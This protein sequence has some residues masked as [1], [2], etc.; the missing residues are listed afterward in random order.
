MIYQIF[1]V[2][3][4]EEFVFRDFLMHGGGGFRGLGIVWSSVVF[5]SFHWWVYDFKIVALLA[6]MA[7]GFIFGLIKKRFDK[8]N[9]NLENSGV[10]AG[11]NTYITGGLSSF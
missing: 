4:I 1:I 11:Y 2:A 5:G 8:G 6:G 9:D 10:H 7:I 3:I